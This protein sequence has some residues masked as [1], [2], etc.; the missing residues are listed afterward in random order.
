MGKVVAKYDAKLDSKKRITLRGANSQYYHV[1][2]KTDGTIE[3]SPRELVNRKEFS[4][5]TLKMIDR[6]IKNYKK[7]K[8]S[9]PI[10]I[11]EIKKL[12]G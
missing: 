11:E 10:D 6:A 7:G 3:L 12:L 5:R 4:E 8:V 9:E 2:E 1:I